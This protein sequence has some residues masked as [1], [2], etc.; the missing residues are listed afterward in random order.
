MTE[1]T[2]PVQ[3]AVCGP[4]DADEAA[5]NLA[6]AVGHALGRRGA[7]LV[8]GGLGGCMEA[9]CRGAKAAGGVTVGI[10]PGYE[11]R[12]ANRYV[13]HAVCTGMGQA[14]NP[15]I[16]A[17]GAAVI[18]V[19]GGAGTL[20]EVALAI[21]LSRPVVLIGEWPEALGAELAGMVRPGSSVQLARTPD[22]AVEM[23]LAESR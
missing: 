17:S 1:G 16:V 20:S 18:A 14:R 8:C 13:D 10:V 15:I 11:A 4:G 9:A 19:A 3:I 12:S 5:M 7:T 23:A 21:R 6:E 2:R 22:E